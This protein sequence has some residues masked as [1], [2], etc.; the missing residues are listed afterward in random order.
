MKDI[1]SKVAEHLKKQGGIQKDEGITEG[2]GDLNNAR[3]PPIKIYLMDENGQF[4]DSN[5]ALL[6]RKL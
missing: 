3:E 4:V 6:K 1:I 5:E 2:E